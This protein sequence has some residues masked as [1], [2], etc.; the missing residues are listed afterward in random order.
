MLFTLRKALWLK[1]QE[2]WIL[3]PNLSLTGYKM[4][5]LLMVSKALSGSLLCPNTAFDQGSRTFS[6]GAKLIEFWNEFCLIPC[7]IVFF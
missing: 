3:V 2:N 7:F 5:G 4:T 6:Y 1:R